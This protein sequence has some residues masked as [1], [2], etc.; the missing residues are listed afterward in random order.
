MT[1][2]GQ[3][4]LG[5]SDY[6]LAPHSVVKDFLT[7]A[8][9][10]PH[11]PNGCS[12]LTTSDYKS[13]VVPKPST[14]SPMTVRTAQSTVDELDALAEAMHRSR[15]Y[16]VNEAIEEYVAS[17]KWQIERIQ[18]GIKALEEGRVRPAEEVFAEIAAKYGWD[19]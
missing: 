19:R 6:G 11:Q 1:C 13:I 16:V 18:A 17:K 15:N 7:T 2:N 9:D 10:H 12:R 14:T 5:S 3:D 8:S 4:I